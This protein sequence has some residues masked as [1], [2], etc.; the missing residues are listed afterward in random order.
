MQRQ[1]QVKL[2]DLSAKQDRKIKDPTA[3]RISYINNPE[4][5]SK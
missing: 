5:I 2:N 1:C 3:Y 4:S